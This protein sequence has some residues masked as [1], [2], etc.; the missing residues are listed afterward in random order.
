MDDQEDT[1][2]MDAY[3]R[4]HQDYLYL[5]KAYQD[6]DAERRSLRETIAEKEGKIRNL[7]AQRHSLME[8]VSEKEGK[9]R[10]LDAKNRSLMETVSEKEKKIRDLEAALK[11]TRAALWKQQLEN[12]RIRRG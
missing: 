5:E 8:T 7:D 4:L 2:L 3:K 12:E 10:D 6:L 1:A 11:E 9:I